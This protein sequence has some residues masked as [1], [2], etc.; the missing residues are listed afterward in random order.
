MSLIILK[1]NQELNTGQMIQR[2]TLASIQ[3]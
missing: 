3:V 2:Y 1:S